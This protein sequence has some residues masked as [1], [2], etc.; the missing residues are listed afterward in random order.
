MKNII[1][2]TVGMS[3]VSVLHSQSDSL[4]HISSHTKDLQLLKND[5][6]VGSGQHADGF[7]L[8]DH[9][10]F[11]ILHGFISPM[12]RDITLKNG[13]LVR[14]NGSF[15]P[16]DENSVL[17][18]EGDHMDLQGR[19]LNAKEYRHSQGMDTSKVTLIHPHEMN[20]E[21]L[22]IPN[23]TLDKRLVRE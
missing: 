3:F 21:I 10:M 4:E 13:T 1:L 23:Q 11:V 18:N 17:F 5:Q 2:L 6:P 14:N 16:K 9:K 20:R 22:S 12:E 15:K 7:L 19:V 8:V